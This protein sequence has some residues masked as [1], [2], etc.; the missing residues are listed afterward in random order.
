MIAEDY[1]LLRKLI[2]KILEGAGFEVIEAADGEEA[3]ITIASNKHPDLL[4]SD[5][6]MPRLNGYDLIKGV[7]ETLGIRDMPIIILTTE[8]SDRSQELAFELG[9]DDYIK[10]PFNSALLIARTTAALRRSGKIKLP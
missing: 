7:R 10:K 6:H 2:K 1:T 4:V 9:A 8:S 3:F 5:I